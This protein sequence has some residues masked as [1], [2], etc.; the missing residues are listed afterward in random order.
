MVI[1][2]LALIPLLVVPLF[3]DLSDAAE[4]AIVGIEWFI[5]AAFVAE[6]VIRLSLAPA[7]RQFV[8]KEWPDLLI[9]LLPFL[10]PLRI[11]RSARA[12]RLLRLVRVAAVLG[13]LTQQ[14][15]RLLLRHQLHY[16]I[17]ATGTIVLGCAA[18]VNELEQDGG[19][20]IQ[21]FPDAMWWAV[22]TVTTV[23]YGDKFPVT[24][25]GRGVATVL[26]L[27]GIAL[28]GVITANLAAFILERGVDRDDEARGLE[29]KLDEVNARLARLETLLIADPSDGVAPLR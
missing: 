12:L 1:L 15:R 28:M 6:Y 17:L 26:M 18:L 10:R 24:A 20:T 14:S 19:G 25:A 11:V 29:A 27:T 16:A 23:G 9:I 22:T 5:W 2:A 4:E 21:S 13:E 8:R 3:V 7:K